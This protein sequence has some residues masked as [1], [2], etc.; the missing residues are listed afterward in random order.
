MD[1]KTMSQTT[2]KTCPQNTGNASRSL[3]AT[4]PSNYRKE[5]C[6]NVA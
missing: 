5:V 1:A 2:P 6:A 3:L 4:N